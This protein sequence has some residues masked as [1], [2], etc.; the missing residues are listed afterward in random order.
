MNNNFY[1][2][3]NNQTVKN[4]IIEFEQAIKKKKIF[5]AIKFNKTKKVLGVITRGDL[6]RLILK[7]TSLNKKIDK[8]LNLKPITIKINELNNDLF[9][10]LEKKSKGKIFDDILLIDEKDKFLKILR[11]NEIKNNFNYKSTCVIGMG[12][13]GLPLSIFILKKFKNVIGY[14]INQKKI[15]DIKNNNLDFFEK[16]LQKLLITH[17]KNKRLKLVNK[18]KDINSEVYIICIGSV[19]K[20]KKIINE[21]LK[22]LAKTLSRKIKKGDL[23]ILRGTVSV[24][25]SREIF[26]KY[27]LKYTN[28]KNGID[29]YF[30]F[31]PER[32][33]EGDAL[34]ELEKVPQLV[35]GSTQKCL[36][37]AYDYSKE[38][39]Q[40]VIKL[41]SLEE[42]EIIKLASNSFRSLNFA[43]SN[44]ISRISNLYGLSGSELINKANF[45]Y[46][47]NNIA[48]PSLGVGGFCLPKDPLLFSNNSKKQSN[49]KLGKISNEI[50]KEI[51]NF[52]IKKFLNLLKK[53]EKPKILV[54]GLT[55]KGL[56]ETLDIRNSTSLEILK[57]FLKKKFQCYA[58]DP[59]G[60]LLNRKLKN[61]NLKILSNNF[62]INKFDLVIIVN[63]HPKFFEKIENQLKENKS[64]RIKYIFDTWGNIDKSFVE[65]LGWKYLNI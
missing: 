55:F 14:D 29:F 33:V 16:N 45:G 47:R 11:Y 38:I 34:D 42:G 10:N 13:I 6:R 49:Y 21:N 22:N 18:L 59:L 58:Y 64:H 60:H 63:N 12:H 37:V 41:E 19:I 57:V 48:K 32:L 24:G 50:N 43:F 39:F 4:F 8:F 56:P 27:I 62:D 52:F 17:L 53:I 44:E 61:R 26:L 30:S 5:T 28:M 23:I 54:M 25:T 35:S 1:S 31:M 40:N 3:K 65:N 2:I 9:S 15:N 46:E 51:T 36:Q 20:N 7:N